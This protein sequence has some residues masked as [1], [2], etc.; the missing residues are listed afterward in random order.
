PRGPVPFPLAVARESFSSPPA[1]F[2]RA[3]YSSNSPAETI[4]PYA[5]AATPAPPITRSTERSARATPAA[6]DATADAPPPRRNRPA[7]TIA[8]DP[9]IVVRKIPFHTRSLSRAALNAGRIANSA[10]ISNRCRISPL[11]A[12]NS[13]DCNHATISRVAQIT[14]NQNRRGV[15]KAARPLAV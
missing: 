11:P 8:A 3:R 5:R 15:G 6:S 12:L 7:T 2:A 1:T 14:Q 10:A 13:G 4:P 9:T